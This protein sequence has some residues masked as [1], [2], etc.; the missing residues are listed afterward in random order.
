MKPKTVTTQRTVKTLTRETRVSMPNDDLFALLRA[1]L[2]IPKDA[3]MKV[4]A[5]G[6]ASYCGEEVEFGNFSADGLIVTWV[7]E[8]REE[9]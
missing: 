6:G 7:E 8:F 1:H 4:C 2:S 3:A 9:S 5:D